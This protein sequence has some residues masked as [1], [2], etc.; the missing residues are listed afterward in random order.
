[1]AHVRLSDS[2]PILGEDKLSQWITLGPEWAAFVSFWSETH[3]NND[4]RSYPD[5]LDL[6]LPNVNQNY[7]RPLAE[8]STKILVSQSYADLY[9]RIKIGFKL[10]SAVKDGAIVRRR[11]VW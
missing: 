1:M 5:V 2:F 8:T 3:N 9:E 6:K 7:D 4:L 10:D 11:Y